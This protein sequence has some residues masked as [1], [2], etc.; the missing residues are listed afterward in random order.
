MQYDYKVPKLTKA[1]AEQYIAM[2]LRA[3]VQQIDFIRLTESPKDWKHACV[4]TG[5]VI[6]RQ[7]KLMYNTTTIEFSVCT[8]CRKVHYFYEGINAY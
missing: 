4:P 6:L 2:N 7:H 1:V 8:A 5:A 3:H